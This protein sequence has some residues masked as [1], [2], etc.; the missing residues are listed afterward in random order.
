M[1]KTTLT[2]RYEAVNNRENL[3]ESCADLGCN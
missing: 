1:H 2:V 3:R